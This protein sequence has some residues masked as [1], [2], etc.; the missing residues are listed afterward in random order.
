LK[1]SHVTF[2]TDWSDQVSPDVVFQFRLRL[3]SSE[4]FMMS[5]TLLRTSHFQPRSREVYRRLLQTRAQRRL[6]IPVSSCM[7]PFA[8]TSIWGILNVW[9]QK[10]SH[11]TSPEVLPSRLGGRGGRSQPCDFH[12]RLPCRWLFGWSAGVFVLVPLC[13][14]AY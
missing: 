3:S 13:G 12:T 7:P 4:V 10:V 1:P 11:Y 6:D 14:D 5:A 2:Q 8:A 9:L